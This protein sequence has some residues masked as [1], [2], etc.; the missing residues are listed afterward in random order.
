MI[1]ITAIILVKNEEVHLERLI[2]NLK[3]ICKRI[4]VVDS[5]SDD[6]SVVLASDKGASV[7]FNPWKNYA[8]QFNWALKNCKINTE[9]VLRID[10]DEYIDDILKAEIKKLDEDSLKSVD[11]FKLCRYMN[12]QGS[13]IKRG[14]LFPLRVTRLFRKSKGYCE[15][16]WM[17]EHII[18]DGNLKELN[19]KLIDDNR[20]DLQWWLEKHI[21]YSK[22]EAVDYLINKEKS[23][24][25]IFK[26]DFR[27]RA[28]R[29]LKYNAYYKLPTNT[30]ATAYFLYRFVLRLGFA[31]NKQARNFHFLQG[32]WYRY[33]VDIHIER[34]QSYMKKHNVS[35]NVAI[36]EI[37]GITI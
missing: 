9:W 35:L 27:T 31:D 37:L 13:P 33:I 28:K 8:T 6:S 17:D 5:G 16:T 29:F 10:A 32:L 1:D 23:K 15:Q 2:F 34:V 3:D 18:V 11:G 7:F 24:S 26:L 21:S 36:K 30:R 12:F 19:G 22:R 14:G 25:N 4:C 20:N